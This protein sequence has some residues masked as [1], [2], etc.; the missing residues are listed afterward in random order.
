MRVHLL[1]TGP[2]PSV[3]YSVRGQSSTGSSP[4]P[5]LRRLGRLV[6][7]LSSANGRWLA[8]TP[9][10]IDSN[11]GDGEDATDD[12]CETRSDYR[13]THPIHAVSLRPGRASSD[14]SSVNES[15]ACAVCSR[16]NRARGAA[17]GLLD[18]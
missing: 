7:A 12:K 1:A 4:V 2:P 13:K 17:N 18:R 11:L 16:W 10:H 15:D 3:R 14:S 6:L 5:P 9:A 8:W